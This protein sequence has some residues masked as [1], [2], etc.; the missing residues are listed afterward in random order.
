ME[1]KGFVIYVAMLYGLDER[2]PNTCARP[3]G[4]VVVAEK[5]DEVF[6]FVCHGSVFVHAIV[7][8]QDLRAIL[9]L[10]KY[11]NIPAYAKLHTAFPSITCVPTPHQKK[12]KYDGCRK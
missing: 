2:Y 7:R 11:H 1:F 9:L 3:V 8:V 10:K 12:P 6:F 4:R 5:G